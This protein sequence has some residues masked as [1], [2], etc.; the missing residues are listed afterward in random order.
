MPRS[1][2]EWEAEF[3]KLGVGEVQA[4]LDTDVY[5]QG[6]SGG[7]ARAWL[8]RVREASQ[9]EQLLIARQAKREAQTANKIAIVALIVAIISMVITTAFGVIGQFSK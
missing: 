2:E 3:E 6:G 4:R 5:L 8:A 1:R 9:T 7:F